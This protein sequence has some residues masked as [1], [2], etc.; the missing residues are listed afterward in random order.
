LR[1][2]GLSFSLDVLYEGL[3]ISELKFLIPKRKI[4]IFSCILLNLGIKTLDSNPD[5]DS[6]EMLDPDPYPD[7]QRW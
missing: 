4:I 7:Q 1:A 3:G 2:E 6:L 5:P